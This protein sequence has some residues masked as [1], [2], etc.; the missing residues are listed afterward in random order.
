MLHPSGRDRC[1]GRMH[2]TD[3]HDGCTHLGLLD[4]AT[5]DAVRSSV[6]ADQAILGMRPGHS[7]DQAAKSVATPQVQVGL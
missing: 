6:G 5:D 3:V 4:R 2:N 7:R 1:T